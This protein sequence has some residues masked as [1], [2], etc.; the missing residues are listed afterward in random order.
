MWSFTGGAFTLCGECYGM[1]PY[2][3]D[4]VIITVGDEMGPCSRVYAI[5]Y[6]A[7]SSCWQW[8]FLLSGPRCGPCLSRKWKHLRGMAGC[9]GH[10]RVSS[11]LPLFLSHKAMGN[12]CG[13]LVWG[14]HFYGYNLAYSLELEF[15]FFLDC[16]KA[17]T[18]NSCHGFIWIPIWDFYY[19]MERSSSPL[20]DGSSLMW[21]PY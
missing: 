15:D 8:V 14:H 13:G 21:I 7:F 2:I 12:W 5:G 1:Y 10:S 9:L 11:A 18:Y 4:R 16:R 6:A 19:S 3:P 17:P 20:C